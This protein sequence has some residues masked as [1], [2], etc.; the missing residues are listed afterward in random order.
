MPALLFAVR[1]TPNESTGYA[2][3]RLIFGHAVQGPLTILHEIWTENVKSEEVKSTYQ[4]ML[5][6]QDKIQSTC[7]L[8]QEELARSSGKYKKYYDSRAKDRHFSLVTACWF[9][10]QW[11]RINS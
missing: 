3:F 4:Y 1:E 11:I 6:L 2:P 5:D 7:K 8:K 10:F 9:C